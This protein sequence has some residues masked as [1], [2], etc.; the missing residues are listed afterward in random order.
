MTLNVNQIL[1]ICLIA[2]LVVFLV[3]L[4]R[5]AATAIGVLKNVNGLVKSAKVAADKGGD[6]AGECKTKALET[7]DALMENATS[8]DKSVVAVAAALGVANLGSIIRKHS[9]LGSGAIG[10][11]L[12]KRDRKRA[13]KEYRKTKKEVAKLRK[14][15][16]KEAKE[17]RKA[18]ALARSLRKK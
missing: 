3:V 14:A 11:Y 4:G 9:F 18:A 2:E 5:M 16:R 10:A 17:S 6:L 8:V 12:D 7:A 15:A 13:Q 1:I